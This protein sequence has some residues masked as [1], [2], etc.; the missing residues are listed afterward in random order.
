MS[1]AK[2]LKKVSVY[3]EKGRVETGD[4]CP[5]YLKCQQGK[6]EQMYSELF[7]KEAQRRSSR[8]V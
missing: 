7:R 6:Q 1:H 8:P 4:S 3:V 5:Q 2:W